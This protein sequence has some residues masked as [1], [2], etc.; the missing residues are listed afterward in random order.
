MNRPT[1]PCWKNT[2]VL[3]YILWHLHF[4]R[5]HHPICHKE[6]FPLQ[7]HKD[8]LL[9]LLKL[10]GSFLILYAWALLIWLVSITFM[11]SQRW[12]SSASLLWRKTETSHPLTQHSSCLPLKTLWLRN[13]H[14][15]TCLHWLVLAWSMSLTMKWLV[16]SRVLS[17]S[18]PPTQS[19]QCG[20]EWDL[21]HSGLVWSG[22]YTIKIPLLF[23]S[24]ESWSLAGDWS[25]RPRGMRYV[26][27]D[28]MI[29][30]HFCTR[31]KLTTPPEPRP[32]HASIV[33]GNSTVF[34]T[35]GSS[36]V[37]AGLLP[38]NAYNPV[39][40]AASKSCSR[41]GY[42]FKCLPTSCATACLKWWKSLHAITEL[43]IELKQPFHANEHYSP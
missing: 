42:N 19:H 15:R 35:G 30:C 23:R 16:S 2:V 36:I 27:S 24:M 34:R 20:P 43:S 6:V 12:A 17:F 38:L 14:G 25:S 32:P 29:S 22:L 33:R 37:P 28:V 13:W 4:P 7:D 41:C 8:S 1:I 10:L 9:L 26:M 21:P 31:G 5:L 3:S 11:G 40:H 18:P 39:S